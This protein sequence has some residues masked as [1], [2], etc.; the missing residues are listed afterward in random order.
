MGNTSQSGMT[1][2]FFSKNVVFVLAAS[3]GSLGCA[4]QPWMVRSHVDAMPSE[5][6]PMTEEEVVESEVPGV[7]IYVPSTDPSSPPPEVIVRQ[8]PAPS[9]GWEPQAL[10]PPNP[11]EKLRTWVG[12]YDCTQ[13]NTGMALR[14]LDVRGRVV[15]AI[16]DF[17]HSA[18]GA[19]GSYIITGTFDPETR[20]VRFDPSQWIARP[21]HYLMVPM[22]G[23]ISADNSLFA[24]KIDY[25]GCGAFKLKPTR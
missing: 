8:G 17:T 18:S 20:R 23:E 3:L 14:I 21:D 15:R 10:P 2:L 4:S 13:G 16:F 9:D 25:P 7:C 6:Q 11:F 5:V 12:N 22:E 19:D 24:G 1:R